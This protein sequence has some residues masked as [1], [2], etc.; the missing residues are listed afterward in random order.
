MSVKYFVIL[1]EGQRTPHAVVRLTGAVEEAF[2]HTLRWEPANLLSRVPA[3][4]TWTVREEELG[5]ANGFLVS[6]VRGVRFQRYE[7]PLT[8]YRY[9]AVFKDTIGVLDLD[10]A[11]MLIRR[12]DDYT[13]ET[14]TGYGRWGGTDKLYRLDSGRDWTEEYI[15]VSE[16]EAEYLK[17]RID[18]RWAEIRRHYILSVDQRPLAVVAVHKDPDARDREVAFMGDDFVQSELMSG[19]EREPSVVVHEVRFAS[20]VE[21]MA[22]FTRLRRESTV[23]QLTGGYAVFHRPTDVLDLYAAEEIVRKPKRTDLTVVPVS[24]PEAQQVALRI[25]VR[26][27][28]RHVKP[29]DGHHYFAVFPSRTDV[30]DVRNAHSVV[31]CTPD[32]ARWELFLRK[33]VWLRSARPRTVFP[34]PIG[35]A[36]VRRLTTML[37]ATRVRYFEVRGELGPVAHVRLDGRNE[38]SVRDLGWEPSDL[39]ESRQDEDWVFYEKDEHRTEMSRYISARM[40]RT[41][42]HRDDARQYFGLFSSEADALALRNALAV[43]RRENGVDEGFAGP[44]GWQPTD[45]LTRAEAS[46]RPRVLPLDEHEAA[47]LT[48]GGSR[49]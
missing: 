18:A 33:G 1:V 29:I 38:A 4:P 13:E 16:A 27:E 11:Y 19:A 47:R 28:R 12:P 49:G 20:A 7:S 25:F 21:M 24:V 35:K 10:N 48:G 31:R 5:Y 6:L 44:A 22:I 26:H 39:L 8:D 42:L 2:T 14:Y 32:Q 30:L 43:V 34:L 40:D 3:E 23:A 37:K 36:D 46:V 45:Q 15:P 17:Q 9:Y 41:V